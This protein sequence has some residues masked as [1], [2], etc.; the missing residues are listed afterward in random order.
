MAADVSV[1][2]MAVGGTALGA[3][4]LDNLRVSDTTIRFNNY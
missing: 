4:H 2:S 3:T 1:E